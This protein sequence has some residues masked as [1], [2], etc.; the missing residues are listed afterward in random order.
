LITPKAMNETNP[1]EEAMMP[2][3]PKSHSGVAKIIW[4]G[5]TWFKKKTGF[6]QEKEEI[7][8]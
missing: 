3:V 5:E 6:G 1:C 4:F 7:K 2:K 8:T